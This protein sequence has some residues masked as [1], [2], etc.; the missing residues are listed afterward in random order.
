MNWF[1]RLIGK[2]PRKSDAPPVPPAKSDSSPEFDVDLF[3]RAYACCGHFLNRGDQKFAPVAEA[4]RNAVLKSRSVSPKQFEDRW[5]NIERYRNRNISDTYR[6]QIIRDAQ[7]KLAGPPKSD[8]KAD[9]AKLAQ[10][11]AR[12]LSSLRERLA[13]QEVCAEPIRWHPDDSRKTSSLDELMAELTLEFSRYGAERRVVYKTGLNPIQLVYS[14]AEY[15]IV[16]T[17][18]DAFCLH[19]ISYRENGDNLP[20]GWHVSHSKI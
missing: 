20:P 4:L 9:P 14:K 15:V 7:E 13:K 8:G 10:D 12:V 1:L 19:C 6:L 2:Q 3:A 16:R 18:E 11:T 5:A 17:G